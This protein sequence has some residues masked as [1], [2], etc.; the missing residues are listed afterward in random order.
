MR[1]PLELRLATAL[2]RG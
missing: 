1:C 2:P